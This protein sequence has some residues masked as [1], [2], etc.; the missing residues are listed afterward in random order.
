MM[1]SLTNRVPTNSETC[2]YRELKKNYGQMKI[3]SQ[4]M[5]FGTEQRCSSTIQGS[6][7]RTPSR[8]RTTDDSIAKCFFSDSSDG[9][10]HK[11]LTFQL[12]K[13]VRKSANILEDNALL[14]K[15][16]PGDMI[17][18]DAL[19][20]STCLLNLYRESNQKKTDVTHD[21]TVKQIRGQVLSDL[22]QYMEH[23]GKD[24][25]KN[26]VFKLVDL[27]TLYKERVI[28]LGGHGS[29]RQLS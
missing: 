2:K 18:L 8:S 5:F 17:V 3:I 10:L 7:K 24:D 14:G 9:T 20:H 19:Y 25:M 21:H 29:E 6:S 27:A 1:P 16:S 13:R 22:A 28:E 26:N 23:V 11:V 4:K 12:E 15:P